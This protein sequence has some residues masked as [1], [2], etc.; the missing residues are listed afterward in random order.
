MKTTATHDMVQ[1]SY[2][3]MLKDAQEN[4]PCCPQQPGR[5][6]GRLRGRRA[7]RRSRKRFLWLR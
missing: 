3:D 2:T 4:Q 5:Q 1:E 6:A 7:A